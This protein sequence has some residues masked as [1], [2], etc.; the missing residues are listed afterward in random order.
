[1]KRDIHASRTSF[2][3]LDAA[4]YW[5]K[6]SPKARAHRRKMLDNIEKG[7]IRIERDVSLETFLSSYKNTPVHDGDKGFRLRLTKK[8]FQN[9]KTDYRI[10]LIRVEER[11]LA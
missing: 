5:K 6:W 2:S 10:Y 8:L 11:V 7:I 3:I 1:M 4:E 9:T